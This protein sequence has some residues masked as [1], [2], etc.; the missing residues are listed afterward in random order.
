MKV[1][2]GDDLS[3]EWHGKHFLGDDAP[4]TRAIEFCDGLTFENEE[5]GDGDRKAKEEGYGD[6]HD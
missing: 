1:R 3:V 2:C 6:N 4:A 5:E